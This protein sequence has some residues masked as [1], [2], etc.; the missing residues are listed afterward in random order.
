MLRRAASPTE[1]EIRNENSHIVN[2][3]FEMT[4]DLKPMTFK[5]SISMDGRAQ[6]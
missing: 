1:T 2:E 4:T 6:P 3:A 5:P